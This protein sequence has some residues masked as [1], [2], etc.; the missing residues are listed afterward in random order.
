MTDPISGMS[1]GYGF[2]RFADEADQQRALNEMQGV[3]CGNR[4]MRISTATPKNKSGGGGGGPGGMQMQG[5]MGG[6]A[7][8][9]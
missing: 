1:R 7:G 5:G 4:P 9:G 8:G 3:Y 6:P 2:V